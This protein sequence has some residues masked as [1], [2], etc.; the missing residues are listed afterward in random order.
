MDR[1]HLL[2]NFIEKAMDGTKLD[3]ILSSIT[4][5]ERE[6]VR[7]SQLPDG[8]SKNMEHT[9]ELPKTTIITGTNTL[10]VLA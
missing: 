4:A 2:T 7:L 10:L 9:A 6:M 1:R 8:T 3:T 5:E